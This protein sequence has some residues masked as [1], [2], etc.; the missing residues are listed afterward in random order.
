MERIYSAREQHFSEGGEAVHT[1]EIQPIITRMA[2]EEVLAWI[3]SVASRLFSQVSDEVRLN[4]V[5]DLIGEAGADKVD[6]LVQL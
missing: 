4:F 2:Q 6:I 5:V 1:E 3:A